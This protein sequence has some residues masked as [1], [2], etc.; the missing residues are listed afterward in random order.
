LTYE[1]EKPQEPIEYT[2]A[3]KEV[4]EAESLEP[5]GNN[6]ETLLEIVQADEPIKDEEK[7]EEPTEEPGEVSESPA[8]TSAPQELVLAEEPLAAVAAE[9]VFEQP[10]PVQVEEPVIVEEPAKVEEPTIA[11][12]PAKVEE[13]FEKSQEPVF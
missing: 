3:S 4:E 5:V 7:V 10:E 8:P 1:V 13:T 12:E 2:P 11:V 9:S 6:S